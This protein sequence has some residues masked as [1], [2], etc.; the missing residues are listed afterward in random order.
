MLAP[1][2][3]RVLFVA[4]QIGVGEGTRAGGRRA[5]GGRCRAGRGRGR[6]GVDGASR[7]GVD[8]ARCTGARRAVR[9]RARQREAGGGGGRGGRVADVGRLTIYV[10]DMEAYRGSRAQIGA[11]Y[12]AVFGKHFPAMS[13][14][15]V[16]ELVDPR[17][18]VE[19][20]ATAIIVRRRTLGHPR[21]GEE[22]RQPTAADRHSLALYLMHP[23]LTPRAIPSVKSLPERIM[24]HAE[25]EPEATPICPNALL[26]LGNRAAVNQA[27][28]RL[29]RS[30]RLM[31]ICHGCLHAPDPDPLWAVCT[32]HQEV[33]AGALA[34]SGGRRSS[35][36]AAVRPTGLG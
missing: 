1:E 19:I 22:V 28:S 2:G 23:F 13:L 25:A 12:R 14:V 24:E 36:T 29:A 20:E 35:P 17:A 10:T 9:S 27:L 31:R 15:A 21:P 32:E 11:E 30:G 6:A 34:I 8:G 7:A 33:A 18:V 5:G 26:H 3:G 4:G 16:T